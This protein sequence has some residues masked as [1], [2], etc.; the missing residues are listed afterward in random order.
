MTRSWKP[1]VEQGGADDLAATST[2]WSHTQSPPNTKVIRAS[3]W[4][5]R[6]RCVDPARDELISEGGE[7]PGPACEVYSVPLHSYLTCNHT[8]L[9]TRVEFAILCRATFRGI[10]LTQTNSFS[11]KWEL[12]QIRSFYSSQ[13]RRIHKTN[14]LENP[15]EEKT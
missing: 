4:D 9:C 8:K 14:L 5:R 10:Y 15:L 1:E 13:P 6:G 11:L 12:N 7:I 2:W 3:K